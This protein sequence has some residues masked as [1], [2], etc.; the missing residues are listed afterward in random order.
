[1]NQKLLLKDFN[2][3]IDQ[4][5]RKETGIKMIVLNAFYNSVALNAPSNK[6]ETISEET[7]S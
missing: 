7:Y 2:L 6:L 5:E 1:M 3:K 4:Y